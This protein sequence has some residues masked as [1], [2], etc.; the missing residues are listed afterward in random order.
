MQ[1]QR[2]S[3]TGRRQGWRTGKHTGGPLAALA[4]AALAWPDGA[5]ADD[6]RRA[7]A[8]AGP[9]PNLSGT[10]LFTD[11]SS[12]QVHP[13]ARP[14]SPQY[15]LWTDGATKRRWIHL[16]AGT[17]IDASRPDQWVFPHGTRFWKE[18]S[19]GGRRIETRTLERQSDGTWRYAAYLWNREGTDAALVPARGIPDGVEV[20]P[21]LRHVIPGEADCRACHE[22]QPTPVLGFGTLQLSTDRDPLAAHAEA[23]P[24]GGVDLRALVEEDLIRGLPRQFVDRPARIAAATPTARAALG[25]LHANCGTC[26]NGEGPLATVGLLLAQEL[27]RGRSSLLDSITRPGHF[28]I[29]GPTG[30]MNGATLPVRPGRPEHSAVVFRMRSRDALAQMPPLGTALVDER[31]LALVERWIREMTVD[32]KR[33]TTP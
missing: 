13:D 23:V 28:R 14:F 15:P 19:F 20:R 21:G 12:Q 4:L 16:P 6:A 18:F 29:P 17:T 33:R 3:R 7:S 32:D 24:A 27:G 1:G 22:G 10:G 31:G 2:E 8:E 9:S 25:Y 11:R 5:A 26:H 30:P